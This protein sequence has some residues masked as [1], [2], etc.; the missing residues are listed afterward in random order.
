[1]KKIIL[2]LLLISFLTLPVIGLTTPPPLAEAP[3]AVDPITAI[4]RITNLA[5][6]ILI[7]L[8]VILVIYGAFLMLTAAGSDD[9]IKKG[10]TTIMYALIA[11]VVAVLARAL[12]IWVQ[13]QFAR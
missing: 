4:A 11:V 1:M 13:A 10:R 9:S 6:G 3:L 5:F 7:L 8:A 2:A 12:I